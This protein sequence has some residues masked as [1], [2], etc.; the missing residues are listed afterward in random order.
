MTLV[1]QRVELDVGPI[2]HGGHCVA[3]WDGRVVF[4]RHCLPGER[5]VA[6]VTEG[7]QASSYLRAD[8][9]E[10]LRP[11]QGRVAAPCQFSGPGRC[12]GCDFQ[13]VD[14]ATQRRLLGEVVSEQLS[15]LAGIER[16]VTVEG[17]YGGAGTDDGLGWRT[18]VTFTATPGGELGLRRHRSHDVLP[19]DPCLIADPAMADVSATRWPADHVEAVVSSTGERLVVADA[20]RGRLPTLELTGLVG[21]DGERLRGRTYVTERVRDRTFRV[22]GAGFWQVHQEAARTLLDAVLAAGRPQPGEVVADLYAGVGLFSAFLADEV[23]GDGQVHSVEWDRH[24]ARDA[25]RNLHN[26]PQVQLIGASAENAFS[27]GELAA[28]YDLVVLDPP[29]AGARAQVVRHIVATAPSRV[30]YVA[31]DPA[32]LARD[33]ATFAEHGYALSSLRAFDLFPMT[34]HVECVALIEAAA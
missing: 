13:H 7:E 8:A 1:G 29:R 11:V 15:R 33:L 3:R 16:T 34:H 32:A 27:R 24:A 20:V 4:V 31:C 17:P 2:A 6:L 5:V 21:A 19:V 22:T 12:G 30:V 25:R 14:I 18:R 23:G 26:L 9:V 28:R 10:V